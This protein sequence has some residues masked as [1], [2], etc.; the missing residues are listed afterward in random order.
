[1][2]QKTTSPLSQLESPSPGLSPAKIKLLL[3]GLVVLLLGALGVAIFLD[4]KGNEAAERFDTLET[5][6]KEYTPDQDP[7]WNNPHGIYNAE[8]EEFIGTLENFLEREAKKVGGVLEAQTRFYIARTAADHILANPE[9]FDRVR[10]SAWYQQAI[11][12][13]TEI[14]DGHPEF[15]M[16]WPSLAQGSAP[17]LTRQFID[18]LEKNMA[19]EAKYLPQSRTPTGSHV[20]V[21]RTERGDLQLRLYEEEAPMLAGAFLRQARSGALDGRA[22]IERREVGSAVDSQEHTVRLG[23]A[24]SLGLEPF[25]RAALA[26]IAKLAQ[27]GG[28]S[29]EST[30][31]TVLHDRG[32]ISAWHDRATEYDDADQFLFVVRRSPLM[33]YDYTPVGKLEGEASLATLDRIYGSPTWR[34]DA[35]TLNGAEW[36]GI[37]DYL[38]APVRIV[39]ALVFD[40][41][42]KRLDPADGEAA[43][44]R[45]VPT[46]DEA[47]LSGLKADAYNVPAPTKPAVPIKDAEPKDGDPVEPPK[48]E[49]GD[50]E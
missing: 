12:Q 4:A 44:G 22:F 11:T 14:R 3:I 8:R 1:M 38:Q 45:V 47:T 19:W 10:R 27:S 32:V 5:I 34:D 18:W 46:A 25:D 17:T 9:L 31:N 35:E 36:R 49:D 50:A 26:A 6:R 2:A 23:P 37:L 15:P 33:D 30:R 41:A 24:Q 42:G 40:A 7:L 16:N 29:P 48:D 13:L 43:P 28:H 21:L 39:K 20:V